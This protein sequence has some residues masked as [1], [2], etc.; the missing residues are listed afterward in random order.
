MFKFRSM[1]ASSSRLQVTIANEKTGHI[2]R[3]KETNPRVTRIGR[4]LRRYSL[5]ELP[6]ILN[7][8]AREMSIVGPRPLP[9]SDLDPD[10]MSGAFAEWLKDAHVCSL[11]LLVCG[12][13]EAAANFRS[14][15]WCG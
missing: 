11:E 2:F 3:V 7:V 9:A 15:R 4:W 12:R 5:D 10:G 13:L 6:Q 1:Y 14:K 8:L